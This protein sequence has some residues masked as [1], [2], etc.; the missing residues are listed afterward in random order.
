MV[1]DAVGQVHAPDAVALAQCNP[2]GVAVN[3]Q[4]PRA[5][6]WIP[7][8]DL[9]VSRHRSFSI[10]GYGLDDSRFETNSTNTMV[11]NIGDVQGAF[12]IESDAMRLAKQRLGRSPSIA[13][14]AWPSGSGDRGDDLCFHIDSPDDVILHFDE[15]HISVMVETDLVRFVELCFYGR[16]AIAGIAPAS[17]TC[18]RRQFARI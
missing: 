9:P 16:S 6:N 18:N 7:Q 13:A 14:K 1:K 8:R 3:A 12:P 5:E 17:A 15:V 10:A 4:C 11:A 2:Q